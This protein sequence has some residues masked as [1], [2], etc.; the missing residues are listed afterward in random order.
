M[1]FDSI[2]LDIDGTIWNTTGI[3]ADAWNKAVDLSGTNARHVTPEELQKEFGKTMNII[4]QDLWPE[5]NSN[6]QAELLKLCCQQEH[7]FI[8]GNTKDITYSSVVETIKKLA[9]KI[10]FYIVSNCQKG[11]IELTIKK[12]GLEPYIKDFECYGNTGNQKAENLALLI[13]RNNLKKPV[14]IGDTQG[15]CDACKKI[16]LPFV[17]AQWGFGTADSADERLVVFSD[18]EKIL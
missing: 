6:Q 13:K 12:T 14:Y 8:E 17:H 11:Y 2:I 1:K 3:V 9:E 7:I 4:A 16:K 10:N 18:L 15:D 5:L